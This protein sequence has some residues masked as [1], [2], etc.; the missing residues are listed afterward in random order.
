MATNTSSPSGHGHSA[1]NTENEPLLGRPGDVNQARGAAICK[2]LIMGTAIVAQ[3]GVIMA[4]AV[5]WGYI[6]AKPLNLASGHALV[7]S[8]AFFVLV[9]SILIQQPSRT[10]EQKHTGRQAH[11]LLNIIAL[12]LLIT[13]VVLIEYN[14]ISAGNAH[15]HSVHAYLGVTTLCIIAVQYLVGV[16]MWLT[17]RLY[18]GEERAKSV[19]KYHRWSGYFLLLLLGCTVSAAA[20]TDYIK[21]VLKVPTW[22]VILGSVLVIVGVYP[23][24]QKQKLGIASQ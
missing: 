7:Q 10:A 6:L 16:T 21:L 23:R 17:P 19:W 24:I 13:G 15:F 1:V 11:L 22:P 8:A 18:G 9:Q 2:N 20:V 12:L 14:K 4:A 3:I 5:V